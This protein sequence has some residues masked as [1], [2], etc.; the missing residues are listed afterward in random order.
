MYSWI[1]MNY[2]FRELVNAENFRRLIAARLARPGTGIDEGLLGEVE[3]KAAH[4]LWEI[5]AMTQSGKDEATIRSLAREIQR[6]VEAILELPDLQAR[7]PFPRSRKYKAAVEFMTNNLNLGDGENIVGWATLLGW[8]FTH[9]LGKVVSEQGAVERSRSW[10]EVV[11]AIQ[12]ISNQPDQAAVRILAN[13]EIIKRLLEAEAKS[14]YQVERLLE[15]V[16]K[17]VKEL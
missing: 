4:L 5:N 14:V 7:Y 10:M 2:P 17:P 6:K 12:F 9:S 16:K 3:Q 8:A 13:H 15:M 11:A 1:S